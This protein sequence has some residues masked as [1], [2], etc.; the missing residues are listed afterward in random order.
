MSILLNDSSLAGQFASTHAFLQSLEV[1]MQLRQVSE[2]HGHKIE[3]S[4]VLLNNQTTNSLVLY[5]A[6][7]TFKDNNK[8]RAVLA[9]ITKAVAS[10]D[11]SRMHSDDDYLTCNEEI[12]TGTA[13]GEAAYRNLENKESSL[14]SFA[15]SDWTLSPI[16]V[17]YFYDN[18]SKKESCAVRN[19]W[20]KESLAD[21]LDSIQAPIQSW[22]VLENRMREECKN[23][24]FSEGAFRPL[25]PQP[26]LSGAS[27]RIVVLL[28]VLDRYT[29]CFDGSGNRMD[30]GDD[31]YQNYFKGDRARFTDSSPDEK[32]KFTNELTF[33]L[34]EGN[35]ALC[36]WHGKIQT[37]Q[38]RIHFS[39]PGKNGD[40]FDIVY[41][42]PK[43]TKK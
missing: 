30:E 21:Y 31:I 3:C 13:V 12:V 16:N 6:I 39:W 7:Q 4:N 38:L 35:R 42:G 43:I 2:S 9:W 18:E 14:V 36:P 22:E 29:Q 41:I 17:D 33:V 11:K 5:E 8:K 40:N 34:P 1:L 24:N 19:Y 15:P 26:F 25:F 28:K 20:T 32:R 27:A 23:L 10:W 37:P